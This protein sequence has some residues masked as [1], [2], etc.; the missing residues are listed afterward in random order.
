M[1]ANLNW[2]SDMLSYGFMQ[3]AIL[4][5]AVLSIF[6]GIISVFI[7]LRRV[8]FMG[9]GISH[10]AF[11]GVAIGFLSGINPLLTA[12]I[13]SIAVAFGIERISA[14]G[15]LAED[16][17]IGIFFSSSMALGIVLIGLSASYNVDLFGYLFGSILAITSED[18][19]I[20]V[21]ITIFLIGI[22]FLIMK[23]LHFITFNEELALVSGIKVRLIKS[24]FLLS[25]AIAIVIGIKLVGIVLISALLVIPGAT[26]HLLTMRFY[27]MVFI[28]CLIALF[29]S[30]S[31]ILISYHLNLAP[32]GTIVLMLSL[33]FFVAFLSNAKNKA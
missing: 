6:S 12:L 16:T 5:G 30:I 11:G 14:K 23:E 2:F 8:S 18:A 7:V 21:C 22:I 4:T 26:A 3:R 10:A 33:I 9:S 31:G 28:S 13:Y 15:R 27:R 32:G 29:S 1:S 24:V 25:M 20:A 19:L 17:A